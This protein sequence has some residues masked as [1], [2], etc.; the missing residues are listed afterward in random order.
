M[1]RTN[2][3]LQTKE[4][5]GN[6]ASRNIQE[7]FNFLSN[8]ETSFHFFVKRAHN[9]STLRSNVFATTP[10]LNSSTNQPKNV[11][12]LSPENILVLIANSLSRSHTTASGVLNPF[13]SR[14]DYSHLKNSSDTPVL[15]SK[16]VVSPS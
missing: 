10:K 2:L 12:S 9:F 8:Y 5:I 16:D 1:Y 4:M 11:Q 13:Y 14:I 15:T 3:T 6:L 7:N